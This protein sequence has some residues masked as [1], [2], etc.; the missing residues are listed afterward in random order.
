M[1][2][3]SQVESQ[4]KQ[5]NFLFDPND[6]CSNDARRQDLAIGIE[7]TDQLRESPVVLQP[8]ICDHSQEDTSPLQG[9][10]LTHEPSIQGRAYLPMMLESW[11]DAERACEFLDEAK[12]KFIEQ[13]Q[14][15][16]NRGNP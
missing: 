5:D 3:G 12:A 6:Y 8:V 13:S 15:L 2:F 11:Q 1:E 4:N 16:D 10:T 14:E 7:D 9:P